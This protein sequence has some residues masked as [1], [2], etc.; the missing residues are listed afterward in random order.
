MLPPAPNITRLKWV[1]ISG[2]AFAVALAAVV[3]FVVA[4]QR[5]RIPNGLYFVILIPLGLTAAAFLF[6]AMRSHAAYKGTSTFGTLELGGP[7]VVLGLV[8]VGGMMANRA[9]TFALT[10]RVHGPRGTSD[11][12]RDGRLTA[13]L[14]GVRRT[15][16]IGADGA[17]VFADVPSDLEGQKIRLIAEVPTFVSDTSSEHVRIPPSHIIDLG[18][19]PNRFQTTMRGSV[20]DRSGHAIR[21]AALNFGAGAVSAVSDWA[22]NFAVSTSVAPGTVLPLTVSL[23]GAVVFDENVTVAEQPAL[24][25]VIRPATR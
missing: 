2:A 11:I 16:N 9:E 13:D 6:G 19:T 4:A 7:V 1:Y 8:I 3:A 12:I 21:G 14:A 23:N 10:V 24:R 25:I 5:M 18:L 20:F 15:A 22:G 17:V